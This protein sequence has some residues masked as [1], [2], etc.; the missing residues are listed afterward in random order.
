MLF[1]PVL[2]GTTASIYFNDARPVWAVACS[3][4]N[5]PTHTTY[6]HGFLATAIIAPPDK[7]NFG[8]RIVLAEAHQVIAKEL[9]ECLAGCWFH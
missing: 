1:L 8:A 9:G 2:T 7:S 3:T 5:V 6:A 4:G